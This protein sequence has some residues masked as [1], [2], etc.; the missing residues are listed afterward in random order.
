MRAI[1]RN[2]LNKLVRWMSRIK[3][4]T[5]IEMEFRRI[6]SSKKFKLMLAIMILPDIIY[7]LSLS[8]I[9]PALGGVK[10]C[11]EEF[12]RQAGEFIL[13]FWTGLPAQLLAILIASELIAGEFDEGTFKLLITK[14]IRKSSI[15][16]GKWMAFVLCMIVISLPALFLL[17]LIISIAYRGGWNALSSLISHDVMIGE[18]A[19]LLG[20]ITYGSFTM[21]LSSSFSKPLYAALTAFTFLTLYQLIVPGL[22]WLENPAKYTLSYH[23]GLFLEECGFV[24]SPGGRLYEGDL[25]ISLLAIYSLNC[26]LLVLSIMI[27]YRREVK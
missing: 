26:L 5:I 20:L 9:S 22:S 16:L 2:A 24:L 11:L 3:I 17:A 7:L 15:V 4:L 13:D 6:V 23:L 1:S 12:W 27:V 8:E 19:V 14:P 21:L 25:W 18:G 10:V